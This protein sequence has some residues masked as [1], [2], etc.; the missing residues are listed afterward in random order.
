MAGGPVFVV[1]TLI[2][3]CGRFNLRL[4]P[5]ELQA[6]FD[7]FRVPEFAPRYNIGPS[8]PILCVRQAEEGRVAEFRTWGHWN[9]QPGG[10]PLINAR[11]ETV[12][13]R[14]SFR[15]S[16][17]F[18]RCLIP[19][20][21]FYEWEEIS[22]T[23]RRPYHV[24]LISGEPMAFAAVY[25]DVG[26]VASM[27]V[28]PNVE[29]ARIID[30]MPVV[31]PR[32][33]WEQYLDPGVGSAEAIQPLLSPLPDGSLAMYPCDPL[34]NDVRN[35]TPHCVRQVARPQQMTLFGH[36][37]APVTGFGTR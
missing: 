17:Q 5:V 36:W 11:A 4:T 30:R 21:G 28:E 15:R 32:T 27:T 35:E 7:L 12:F 2:G 10:R 16:A 31:L 19:V 8:Q 24:F 37:D 22:K 9:A 23:V 18:R 25:D 13:T 34:V 1:I 3:M 26:G 6:F 20:Q 29:M 14:R 33:A